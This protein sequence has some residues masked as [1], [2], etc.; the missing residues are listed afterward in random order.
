MVKP[1]TEPPAPIPVVCVHGI[2]MK[3]LEM[4]LLRHRLRRCGFTPRQFA[5]PSLRLDPAANAS[6]LKAFVDAIDAPLVHY[7]AHS[8][9]GL[10]VLRMLQDF[11][12]S[13]PGR[14]VTLGTPHR[15]SAVAGALA[16]HTLTRVW[17]GHSITGGELLGSRPPPVPTNREVGAIAGSMNLGVGAWS[18]ALDFPRDGTVSVAETRAPGLA[19]HL[20]LPVSHMA[21]PLSAEVARQTCR[22]LRSGRFRDPDPAAA[23]A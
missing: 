12:D 7:V 2:W 19:D 13:P 16:A 17:L 3:G 21:L 9:G 4:G 11:P 14:V 18:R 8:L 1:R 10:V 6:R 5:Y 22:F 15:G 23:G 20:C